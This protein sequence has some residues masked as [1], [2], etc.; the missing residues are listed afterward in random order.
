MQHCGYHGLFVFIRLIAYTKEMR[1]TRH[2]A[3]RA[4]PRS[5]RGAE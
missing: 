4:S 3:L 2:R 1:E 5:R